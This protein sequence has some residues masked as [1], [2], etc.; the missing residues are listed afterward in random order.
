MPS[1]AL[2]L[3]FSVFTKKTH[4]STCHIA[5]RLSAVCFRYKWACLVLFVKLCVCVRECEACG[6]LLQPWQL[7]NKH[8]PV[9][10]CWWCNVELLLTLLILPPH[11]ASKLPPPTPPSFLFTSLRLPALA[12]ADSV[13]NGVCCAWLPP[14]QGNLQ[15][16]AFSCHQRKFHITTLSSKPKHLWDSGGFRTGCKPVEW[17]GS[18]R[19]RV[20]LIYLVMKTV[21]KSKCAAWLGRWQIKQIWP[22]S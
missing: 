7:V 16:H 9:N 11:P 18:G 4:A 21:C 2:L 10:S 13:F 12:A 6:G 20:S 5:A 22:M 8:R 17:R 3:F 19:C 1:I 14:L 15:Q